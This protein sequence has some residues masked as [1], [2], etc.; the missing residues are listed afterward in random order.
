M[1][2]WVRVAGGIFLATGL[3]ELVC[4]FTIVIGTIILIIRIIRLRDWKN[5]KNYLTIALIL[6]VLTALN[7][8]Q[9]QANENTLQSTVIIRACYEGTMNTSHLYF[10][11]NGTFEDI[12]IGWF[13]FVH[14]RKGT[15]RQCKDTLFLEFAGEKPRLLDNKMIIKGD[16]LYKKQGDTLVPTYYYLGYCKGR[17]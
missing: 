12:N 3:L 5:V 16:N 7:M 14:Y 4:F 17:N 8:R 15:W 2:F 11:K 13:A 9:L 10:R 1:Y 6:F